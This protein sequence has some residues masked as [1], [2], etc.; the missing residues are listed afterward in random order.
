MGPAGMAVSAMGSAMGLKVLAIEPN[1]VGGECLNYGCIPSKALLK[2]GEM[3]QVVKNLQEYGIKLERGSEKTAEALE[4]VREKVKRISGPKTMKMFEKVDFVLGEGKAEFLDKKTVKVGDKQYTAKKIFIASGTRPY[5]PPIPGIKDV[6]QLTNLNLFEQESI[7]D[8]LTIIGGGAIGTEMA[9]AFSRLGSKVYLVHLDAHLL[10]NSE[11]EAGKV[12]EEKFRQEG[13]EVFNNTCIEKIE[14]KNGRIFTHTEKGVLESERLLVATGRVPELET[15]KLENAGIKYAESGIKVNQRMRTNVKGI[16]AVGDC[17]G[18]AL[19]SHA[20]MHQGMLALMNA[21]SPFPLS[22][23]KRKKYLVPWTVFTQPEVAHVGLTEKE[24]RKKGIKFEVILEKYE[25]YG[26]TIAD[27]HPEG[28]VK[29]IASKWGKIYGVT[30]AG[31]AASELIHEWILAIQKKIK[32][33]DI[34]MMQHSFPTI[35]LMNKRIAEKWM[36]NKMDSRFL[37]KIIRKL[38]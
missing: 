7:P 18:I 16:Y 3:N 28:F 20:A 17:N 36:M 12:L 31:E 35:S 5:I 1:K 15:L 23:F 24:A 30:I 25:D 33:F 10:P 26:R 37:Q 6:P 27:G 13:I 38:I 34:M 22:K 9:Q 2:A 19:F 11:E 8:S 21:V 29:V 4:V 32:L 14:Q